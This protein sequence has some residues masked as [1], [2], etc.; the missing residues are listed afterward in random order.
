MLKLFAK[1]DPDVKE[2]V[3]ESLSVDDLTIDFFLIRVCCVDDSEF[4][5]GRD[6]EMLQVSIGILV[7]CIVIVIAVES[8]KLVMSLDI[9]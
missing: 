4:V 7:V 1:D 2:V 5:T 8:D 3:S 6:G 9:F